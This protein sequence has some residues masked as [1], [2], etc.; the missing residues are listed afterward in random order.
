MA[1]SENKPG[2]EI[3]NH[4]KQEMPQLVKMCEDFLTEV[5][6]ITRKQNEIM[7]ENAL[8]EQWKNIAKVLNKG[9]FVTLLVI[10]GLLITTVSALWLKAH[11]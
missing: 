1:K 8:Q 7:K 11:Y 3:E 2:R 4:P 10:L 5:K 9:L 6:K